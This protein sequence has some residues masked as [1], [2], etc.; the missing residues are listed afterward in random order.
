MNLAA[1]AFEDDA[2]HAGF[3]AELSRLA[4]LPLDRLGKPYVQPIQPRRHDR[5]D[6]AADN[7]ACRHDWCED[8]HRIYGRGARHYQPATIGGVRRDATRGPAA[9]LSEIGA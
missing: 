4:R 1:G 9:S 3:H 2:E 7:E 6:V 5:S 8:Q